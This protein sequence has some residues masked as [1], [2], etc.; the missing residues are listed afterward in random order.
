VEFHFDLK[1]ERKP[2]IL[3]DGR[4]DFREL[5]LIESV[6]KDRFSVHWFLRFRVHRAERWRIS[7]FRLW[8][9]NLPC[10][11]REKC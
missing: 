10:F 5:N 4:V 2:T 8:T 11:Q 9:E 6:K 1:K 7:R 3:E